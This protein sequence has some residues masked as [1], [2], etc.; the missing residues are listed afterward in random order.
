MTL[1]KD[2]IDIDSITPP[3]YGTGTSPNSTEEAAQ[4]WAKF[5]LDYSL[6]ATSQVG[7]MSPTFPS[8]G[9]NATNLTLSFFKSLIN[10]LFL[11]ELPSNL[12]QFWSEATWAS[13]GYSGTTVPPIPTTLTVELAPLIMAPTIGD[14]VSSDQIVTAIDNFTKTI[15]VN[16][17]QSFAPTVIIVSEIS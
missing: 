1:Q 15:Q 5:I 17:I 3:P 12:V 2:L 6:T 8:Q 16:V 4:I 10:N 14:F 7:L 13:E 9:L 11:E